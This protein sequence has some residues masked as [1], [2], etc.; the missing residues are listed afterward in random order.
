VEPRVAFTIGFKKKAEPYLLRLQEAGVAAACFDKWDMPETLDGFAAL[1][2]G[3]GRDV[4]PRLYGEARIDRTQEPDPERDEK[5]RALLADALRRDLPVFAICR[6]LQ[7]VNVHLGGTL[8]QHIDN[9]SEVSHEVTL[10]EGSLVARASA[11]SRYGIRSRHHQ[12][13]KDLAPGLRVTARA[14]DSVVEAM[15]L[16]GPRFFLAVQWHPE[17]GA[18]DSIHD[19]N[20][21]SAF[22]KAVR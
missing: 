1:M 7:L 16:D 2:L 17:D 9:H 11:G 4:N 20:L 10:E 18:P 12:A 14:D 8:H 21:F 6:G 13:I 3:G 19:A 22:A 5:E 15:E